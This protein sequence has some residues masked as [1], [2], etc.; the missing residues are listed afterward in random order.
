M[1]TTTNI[2]C[3]TQLLLYGQSELTIETNNLIF[4]KVYTYIKSTK[5]FNY[6]S[7]PP[8][9]RPCVL[10]QYNCIIITFLSFHSL[11]MLN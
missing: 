6:W 2:Q 9:R 5:R 4:E 8:S 7:Y 3:S 10:K 11:P 1:Q